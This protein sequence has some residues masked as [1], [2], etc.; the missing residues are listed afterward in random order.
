MQHPSLSL[1]PSPLAP[2]HADA[3]EESSPSNPGSVDGIMLPDAFAGASRELRSRKKD[4][5]AVSAVSAVSP[6]VWGF[7]VVCE[8]GSSGGDGVVPT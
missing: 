2:S 1:S 8:G 7:D 6:C 4:D 5:H 3:S